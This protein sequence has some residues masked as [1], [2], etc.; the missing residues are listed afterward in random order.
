M[1]RGSL[2]SKRGSEHLTYKLPLY[3]GWRLWVWK[4]GHRW[5]GNRVLG[6]FAVWHEY[7]MT[8]RFMD[9]VE[10]LPGLDSDDVTGFSM[11]FQPETIR[12][13]R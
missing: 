1:S 11:H 6:W 8:G 5:M 12:R 3:P 13:V 2:E 10:V 4:I 9:S 7:E